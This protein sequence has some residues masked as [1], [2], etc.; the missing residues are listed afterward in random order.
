MLSSLHIENVALIKETTLMFGAGFT[1]L[2]GETGAGKSIVI[3]ALS[4]L[5]GG[6][7]DRELI[8]S[9]ESYA[10]V[11]GCFEEIDEETAEKLSALDVH[12]DEDGALYL[13]R[14]V[15]ADGRSTAR[16]GDRQVP[17]SR[18]RAVAELL[19]NIHGQQDTL[20]LADKSRH[21]PLLD[22]YADSAPLLDAYGDSYRRYVELCDSLEELRA[23]V[24]DAA[25]KREMLEYKLESLK[26]ARLKSGEEEE[27]GAER[28]LLRSIEKIA[29]AADEAYGELYGDNGSAAE[30]VHG[31]I[32]SLTRIADSMPDGAE[33]MD[34]LESV[35]CEINDIA[36][37][38]RGAAETDVDGA[39]E[40]LDAVEGRLE[41]ISTLKRRFGTDFEGLLAARDS[42]LAELEQIDNGEG[43]I[44]EL[45][46]EKSMAFTALS[47][48]AER[49]RAL[50]KE[51]AQ[52]LVSELSRCL[53]GLDMPSVTFV[54][55]FAEKAPA[56]DGADDVEILISA[57]AGEVPKPLSK[58]ASGGELAR[59]ML[60][61]K[62]ATAATAPTGTMVFDEIDT[63]ISGK[64]AQKT[65]VA[66]KGLTKSG[67]QVFCVTHSA[68]IAALA[69]THLLVRKR[70]SEGRTVSL[71]RALDSEGRVEEIARII[72]GINVGDAARSAAVELLAEAEKL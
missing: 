42:L 50:R 70:E 51:A 41:L 67:T 8:R 72:G 68:Q 23:T 10:F 39:R 62:T 18:L 40:R 63:G 16:I 56:R 45:E 22:S 5:C 59:I 58:I 4:L 2:T 3:D 9:G 30:R 46:E 34:R 61:F 36:D 60:A 24:A 55:E 26:K 27:L 54:V 32:A 19:L 47:A 17:S 28:K 33:L 25:F 69:D 66:L 20:L 64:T 38:L 31:A 49:L 37:T 52:T 7:S 53:A 43:M 11:E 13:S 29:A 44:K 65:G 15:S 12:P 71:V 21:L 57:N 6:R 14:R 48:A 1:V 35:K